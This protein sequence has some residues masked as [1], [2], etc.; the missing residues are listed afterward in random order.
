VVSLSASNWP[1]HI[2]FAMM[3]EPVV[4]SD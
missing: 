1:F 4:S 3:C 2:A